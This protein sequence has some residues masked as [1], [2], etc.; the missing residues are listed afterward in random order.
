[1]DASAEIELRHVRAFVALSERRTITAAARTLGL[2]QSTVSEAILA[3]ERAVGAVLV[4]RA[5]GRERAG[6]TTAGHALLPHAR[7]VLA[8]VADARS[9]LANV[10]SHARNRLA[11][12]ASESVATYILPPVLERL[13][14]EWH[15]TR[16]SVSVR[17]CVGVRRG[18]A[19]G[20]FDVG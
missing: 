12:A 2:A 10:T 5:R 4:A 11:I 18:V 15:N 3:L 1:M 19:A 14:V 8:A 9:A 20:K 17:T 13:G 16:I 7:A 6:L